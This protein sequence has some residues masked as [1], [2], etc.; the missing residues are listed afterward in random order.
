MYR[1]LSYHHMTTS[2]LESAQDRMGSEGQGRQDGQGRMK[3]WQGARG[4][5]YVFSPLLLYFTYLFLHSNYV[6]GSHHHHISTRQRQQGSRPDTSFF[7]LPHLILLTILL[8]RLLLP[9]Y[10]H[11]SMTTACLETV[12]TRLMPGKYF[13]S[14]FFFT[15]LTIFYLQTATTILSTQ[16]Q[17]LQI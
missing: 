15:L 7:L 4:T 3:W 8:L 9:P 13:F 14:S 11:L 10:L 6:Y 12:D 1:N 2:R 5:T 16:S 17:E